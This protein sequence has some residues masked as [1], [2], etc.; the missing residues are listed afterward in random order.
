MSTQTDPLWQRL[1][2]LTPAR[3][4]VLELVEAE[5]DRLWLPTELAREAGVSAGEIADLTARGV[6]RG[7]APEAA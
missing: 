2:R 6:L 5:P 4:K 3:E 7:V 1:A